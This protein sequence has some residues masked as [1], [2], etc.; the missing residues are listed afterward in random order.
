MFLNLRISNTVWIGVMDM[1]ALYF[2]LYLNFIVF[3]LVLFW[4]EM[5]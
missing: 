5:V 3:P 4:G 2:P 1:A